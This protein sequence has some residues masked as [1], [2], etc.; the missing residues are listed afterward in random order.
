MFFLQKQAFSWC[1]LLQALEAV[2]QYGF[3]GETAA[4]PHGRRMSLT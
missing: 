1:C 4:A 2:K 3:A